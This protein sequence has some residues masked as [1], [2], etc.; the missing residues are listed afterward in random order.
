MPT[1]LGIGAVREQVLRV[2]PTAAPETVGFA[3]DFVR[4]VMQTLGAQ[5]DDSGEDDLLA[6]ALTARTGLSPLALTALLKAARIPA[7]RAKIDREAL[8]AFEARFGQASARALSEE[9]R[10]QTG[11]ADFA[12]E[13]GTS[14]ALLLLDTLFAVATRRGSGLSRQQLD[15]LRVAARDLGVDE[16][17]VTAL[18]RKHAAGLVEGDH[19]VTLGNQPLSIGRSSACDICLP[20]PQ[21]AQLHVEIIPQVAGG[22][23]VVDQGSGRPTLWN[24]APISSAPLQHG[25]VL[26]IAHFRLQV[27]EQGPDT[28]LVIEGERSFSA[29]SV[30][31]LKRSIGDIPLLDDIS[32][33]VFTGEVVAVVGPSGAGKT[34]LLHA[35]SAITPAD[36]GEV[37]LDGADFHQLLE[38]DRSQVGIVP[39]DDLVHAELTVEESLAYSGRLRFAG[40]V[41]TGEV[42]AEAD[43][44]LHE[45][46]I[47][48]IRTQR[49]GDTLRR[50]VSGGQRKRVN[51][52]QE[53]MSRSTR[54]LFLD[55]PTSGLDPRASQDI[56]R[57]VRQLAD[58]GR[59]I[60][61]VTHDL[62]PEVLA[63][64]DHLLVLA[65]GGRLAFFGPPTEAARYFQ[66]ATPDAIFNRFVDHRPE[67]WAALFQSSQLYRKYVTTR[68]HL[69]G[70]DGVDRGGGA[71]STSRP[72]VFWR[73]L[74]TLT[75]RYAR[76][77]IRDQTGLAVMVIQPIFLALVM[78]IVFPKA[79]AGFF[80]MLSLSCM[81]FGLSGGVRELITDRAIWRRESRIGVGVLPY[82]GSKAIVLGLLTL[83]QCAG[84]SLLMYLV[85]DL[86]F[87]GF[88]LPLLA[89]VSGLIGLSGMAI[90]LL[91]SA[92]WT[93]SEAAVGT[94]PLLLIP[95]IAFSG[96]IVSIRK[97]GT[98]AEGIT[99]IT[100][101]RYAFDATMK[102]GERV[103]HA[104]RAGRDY[105]DKVLTGVLA[106]LGLKPTGEGTL[107]KDLGL[108]LPTLVGIMAAVTVVSLGI[109]VA[110]VH[111]RTQRANR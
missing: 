93:S 81:W 80:F 65:P 35:I 16:V 63:Q 15:L 61:L 59:I 55:E 74:R 50:G 1:P 11:L 104:A 66:V 39:Q 19:R 41:D 77:R 100:L 31:N 49:I 70:I 53:L 99:W 79:T 69:L 34:T 42:Q 64:V 26:Q 111:I 106:P 94:L 38:V 68:D 102:C 97:M 60:F 24:G 47:H 89:V 52:G 23:R 9:T 29:L 105:D 17:L 71:P 76:T 72:G 48:H 51:L 30:R 86:G 92:I 88:S 109:T 78:G 87:L 110:I 103:W 18:L 58:R 67:T 28:C 82:V 98:L 27:V 54:V 46:D 4:L 33:T 8:R 62:T 43:R 45:L 84:L 75:E 2:D 25:A 83:A 107:A 37:L 13:H 22:W 90:G 44:V 14:E 6:E 5:T 12:S 85:H 56:V 57:L 101:Q 7:A 91:V 40:D 108:S 36:S 95:Q 20:D 3:F 32:F 21:V 73:H 10:H 96:I